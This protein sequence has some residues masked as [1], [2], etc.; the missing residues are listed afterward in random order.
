MF[1]FILSLPAKA[2][3]FRIEDLKDMFGKGKPFKLT[4]G[5]SANSS[6]NTGNGMQGRAPFIYYLNGSIN[7]NIYGQ[8]NL[9]FAFNLTNSGS[10]FRL[11]SIPNRLS[12]HP[13]Y[14]WISGHI[15]DIS[16]T[17][18][19]YTLSG[20]MFTGV[21]VDLQ[22]EGWDFSIMYGRLL[23]AVEY[24]AEAPSVL[25]SFKRMGYG[26]KAGKS[27]EK[28]QIVIN[29][30]SAKDELASLAIAPDSF[31]ISP[32]ENLA[33]SISFLLKPV[34]FIEI[35]G[36]YALSFLT[37]DMRV[38]ECAENGLHK[39]WNGS[40]L[41]TSDYRAYKANL[42]YVGANNRFGVRYEHIDPNYRTLGAYYFANDLENITLNA[43]QSL[44]QNKISINL[45]AGIEHDDL[46][47][48]KVSASSRFVGSAGLSFAPSER[49]NLNLSYSNFQTYSNAR[50]NFEQINQENPL[51]RLDT[52]SFVQLSQS[53]GFNLSLITKKTE[54][55][56][57]NLNINIAYQ[58]A[59]NKQSGIFRPGSVTE[60]INGSTSYSWSFLKSGLTLNGAL[61][62]NN[63]KIMNGNT[64][65]WGPTMGLN[66]RFLDK[67]AMLSLSLSYN[68]GYL[69][70][71][72]QHE[73]LICRLN[74]S[75]SPF[76]RSSI[77][78]SYDFQW[79]AITGR[80]SNNTSLLTAG[81]AYTF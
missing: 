11:P 44:W 45:S 13:S 47:N 24:D 43:Y 30:L 60:M 4:G 35:G 51:D 10:S 55:E 36:E 15:G 74:S 69:E 23:K 32:M 59:A 28:Y 5:F 25:P 75:Y 19:P 29:M 72:K 71:I 73:V 2:Q 70:G 31:G 58:D 40:N 41:T 76:Q 39:G 14:K 49:V 66:S 20:H 63:S 37:S 52:L 80:Q 17:F 46:S 18:S 21:G 64:L 12:L 78:L 1:L 56:L 68:S 27:G 77:T 42:D 61:N 9:P 6:L 22:P 62:I 50:S 26:V 53:G 81:Y 79:R 16:M 8:L 57:H 67:K 38:G 7:L 34:S 3:S 65:T 33:G 48:T 54:A